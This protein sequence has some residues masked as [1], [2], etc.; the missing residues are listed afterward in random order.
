MNFEICVEDSS[1]VKLLEHLLPKLF[2]PKGEDHDW[3]LH[4]YKGVGR[5][6]KGLKPKTDASKRILLDQLPRILRGFG[7][8]P[9]VDMIVVVVDADDRNC[10]AFL[11]E[12]KQKAVECGAASKTLFRLAVEETEAWY[13][14]D[15]QA[16]MKAYPRAKAKVLSEYEQDSICGTW[17]RLADALHPGGSAAIKQSGWPTAG[18]IKHEWA[19]K[20][21]PMMEPDRNVSPSFGKLRDGLRRLA[22]AEA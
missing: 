12:L 22:N 8:S 15:Q 14:G 13:F 3:R 20:I 17:E 21:G 5:L 16:L 6:S 11:G 9:G 2:G 19:E 4:P 18:Q 1:T 7:K 10:A